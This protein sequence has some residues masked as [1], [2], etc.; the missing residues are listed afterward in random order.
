MEPKPNKIKKFNQPYVGLII[1]ILLP[2]ISFLI[3]FLYMLS[4]NPELKLFE[5]IEALIINDAF[6]AAITICV[7]PNMILFFAWKKMD[8][9]YAIKGL[10]ISVVVYTALVILTKIL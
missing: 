1:G 6:T 10:I 2:L 4:K 7:L 3:Y 5:F 9:W 8:Y